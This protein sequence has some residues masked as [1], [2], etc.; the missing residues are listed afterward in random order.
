MACTV[1]S[2]FTTTPFFRPREGCEPIPTISSWPS[3][4]TSPTNATTLEVPMS[5]PTIILP[6]CTVDISAVFS[7]I[8]GAARGGRVAHR[9]APCHG[10]AVGITQVDALNVGYLRFQG[11][12][13]NGHQAMDFFHD[14]IAPEQ[15][16]DGGSRLT[17]P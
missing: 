10:Q 17:R 4:P 6:L 15:E 16:L 5:R 9:L 13:I 11:L 8:H 14:V 2:I 3:S 12:V 1:A 7:S